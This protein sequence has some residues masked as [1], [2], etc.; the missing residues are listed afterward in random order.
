MDKGFLTLHKEFEDNLVDLL[1]NC[2]LPSVVILDILQKTTEKI[3]HAVFIQTNNEIN[4]AASEQF[5]K[6]IERSTSNGTSND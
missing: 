4:L 2:G 5:A 1:N 3:N 6:D